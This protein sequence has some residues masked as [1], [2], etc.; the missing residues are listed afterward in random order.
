MEV[1]ATFLL[2]FVKGK[3]IFFVYKAVWHKSD[4]ILF[5]V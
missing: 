2:V 5:K 1:N 3:G 4:E